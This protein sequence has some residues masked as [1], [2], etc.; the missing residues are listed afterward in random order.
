M[1]AE[2]ERGSVCAN[3]RVKEEQRSGIHVKGTASHNSNFVFH[4][5]SLSLLF[6]VLQF[7]FTMRIRLDDGFDAKLN[8]QRVKTLIDNV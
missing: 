8:L 1:R 7:Y 5:L 4:S 3:F 2:H 6:F